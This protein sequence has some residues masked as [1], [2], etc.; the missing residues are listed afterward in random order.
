M[1]IGGRHC[2][3]RRTDR[4]YASVH[5]LPQQRLYNLLCLAYGADSTLFA[6]VTNNMTQ[7]GFIPKRRHL[8]I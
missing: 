3:G 7:M 2:G 4:N 1:A 6:D 8:R 5:G